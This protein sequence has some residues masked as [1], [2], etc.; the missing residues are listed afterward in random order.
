MPLTM[1]RLLSWLLLL[2]LLLQW[3]TM[4]LGPTRRVTR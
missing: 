3:E 2:Q 1:L 4:T